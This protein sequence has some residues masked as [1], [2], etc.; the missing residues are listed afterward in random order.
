M[1]YERKNE[2]RTRKKSKNIEKHFKKTTNKQIKGK[3][4][5]NNGNFWK[6]NL[7]VELSFEFYNFSSN[8]YKRDLGEGINTN[9][10]KESNQMH[11]NK[12]LKGLMKQQE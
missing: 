2:T 10:G 7:Q 11:N 4:G 9:V 5:E 1:N 6:T 8:T 12:A 3:K